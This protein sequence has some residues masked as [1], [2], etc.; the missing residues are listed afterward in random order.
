M[1]GG[2]TGVCRLPRPKNARRIGAD[3]G[4]SVKEQEGGIGKKGEKV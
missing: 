1:N 2:V 3:P 4:V